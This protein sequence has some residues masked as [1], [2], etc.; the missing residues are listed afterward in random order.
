MPDS[1]MM[2][3]YWHL[4]RQWRGISLIASLGC[5]APCTIN[6]DSVQPY[7]ADS[8]GS[9]TAMLDFGERGCFLELTLSVVG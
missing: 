6:C 8:G 3:I 2:G 4:K 5:S 7:F 9:L 1:V